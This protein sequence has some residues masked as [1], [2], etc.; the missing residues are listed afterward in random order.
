MLGWAK[1]A[2]GRSLVDARSFMAGQGH[3]MLISRLRWK[4]LPTKIKKERG[5]RGL[6]PWPLRCQ[7]QTLF[8]REERGAECCV[9]AFDF[10][11]TLYHGDDYLFITY[12]VPN[13]RAAGV[14]SYW[15]KYFLPL[16]DEILKGN[17]YQR[18]SPF[19]FD[20]T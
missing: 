19:L 2:N 3:C 10:L 20:E 18:L 1:E 11:L 17:G 14:L 6:G 9:L 5:R 12:I 7:S 16:S 8:E 4:H 15:I 13:L